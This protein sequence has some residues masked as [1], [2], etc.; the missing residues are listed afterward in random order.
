MLVVVVV[1]VVIL[2]ILDLLVVGM[3]FLLL[4]LIVLSF[5]GICQCH[6][7]GWWC[8]CGCGWMVGR[9]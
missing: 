1:D 7:C 9:R 6:G 3:S 5:P 2:V 4:S 8:G